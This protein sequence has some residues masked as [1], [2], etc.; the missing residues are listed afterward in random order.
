MVQGEINFSKPKLLT[1]RKLNCYLTLKYFIDHNINGGWIP[2]HVF[3]DIEIGAVS[4]LRSLRKLNTEF[5]IVYDSRQL[6]KDGQKTGT[7]EY[8]LS[9]SLS[10]RDFEIDLLEVDSFIKILYRKFGYKFNQ[11]F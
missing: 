9:Y 10:K 1:G 7:W 5:N 6:E 3:Q 2:N 11:S 4:G 8:K